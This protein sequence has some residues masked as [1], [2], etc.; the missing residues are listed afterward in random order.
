MPFGF[1]FCLVKKEK[2]WSKIAIHLRNKSKASKILQKGLGKKW[3]QQ[4]GLRPGAGGWYFGG[5]ATF[6]AG[7]GHPCSVNYASLLHP[8]DAWD[9]VQQEGDAQEEE[10]PN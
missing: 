4:V 3:R 1:D 2:Q 9:N 7:K 8:A 10:T 5:A 6:P